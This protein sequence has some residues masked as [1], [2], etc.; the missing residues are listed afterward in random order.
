MGLRLLGYPRSPSTYSA[1]NIFCI[2]VNICSHRRTYYLVHYPDYVDTSDRPNPH[3]LSR[4]H[5]LSVDRRFA[6]EGTPPAPPYH[7]IP[8]IHFGGFDTPFL[9]LQRFRRRSGHLSRLSFISGHTS[10]SRLLNSKLMRTQEIICYICETLFT[11]T[12]PSNPEGVLLALCI[13]DL[14]VAGS[15]ARVAR[16][17]IA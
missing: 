2:F 10:H 1:G 5:P 12:N 4:A 13:T 6:F 3:S 7:T 15:H 11:E 14:R 17:R 9:Y 8:C 16:G